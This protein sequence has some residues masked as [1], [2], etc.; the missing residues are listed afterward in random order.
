M[1]VNLKRCG[2]TPHVKQIAIGLV[3]VVTLYIAWFGWVR[4]RS[5]PV[6]FVDRPIRSKIVLSAHTATEAALAYLAFDERTRQRLQI[7][8]L[9]NGDAIIVTM[10]DPDC[11]DDSVSRNV[12]S[13]RL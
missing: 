11:Q 12:K 2:R 13:I 3:L 8:V 7:T 1:K 4:L 5:E 10:I 9:K 6:L